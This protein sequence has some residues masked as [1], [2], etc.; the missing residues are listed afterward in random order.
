MNPIV[1]LDD[2]EPAPR[3][4]LAHP[5]Q[6]EALADVLVLFSDGSAMSDRWGGCGVAF[7]NGEH[8]A[9]RAVALGPLARGSYAAEALGILEALKMAGQMLRP[10]Q[11]VVEIC[12]DHSGLV[13]TIRDASEGLSWRVEDFVLRVMAERERLMDRGIEV[14]LTWVKGHDIHAGNE[15]A[16][17]LARIGAQRSS[18][19]H[20]GGSWENPGLGEVAVSSQKL[21]EL[22]QL[23]EHTTDWR[24]ATEGQRKL[25]D[26]QRR[27]RKVE[28]RTQKLV[29]RK[30]HQP[31]HRREHRGKPM[32][33]RS[34]AVLSYR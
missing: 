15:M 22:S 3:R 25:I 26:V 7:W 16:D 13:S 4:N 29:Y 27:A 5:L 30:G 12:V 21:M 28:R 33:L 6:D 20:L 1:I 31:E 14:R 17:H 8:W 18:E 24:K 10:E 9:G 34:G 23:A 19:G 2:P 32:V 11:K